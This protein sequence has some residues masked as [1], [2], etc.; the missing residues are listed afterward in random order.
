MD[1]DSLDEILFAF[2]SSQDTVE[3]PWDGSDDDYDEDDD[4]LDSQQTMSNSTE[5]W[6]LDDS[7]PAPNDPTHRTVDRSNEEDTTNNISN[8]LPISGPTNQHR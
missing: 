5:N 8:P 7:P 2:P 6:D 4:M 1:R 3:E